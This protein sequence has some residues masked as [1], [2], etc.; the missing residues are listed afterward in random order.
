M[1]ELAATQWWMSGGRPLR[2]RVE[3]L[4]PLYDEDGTADWVVVEGGQQPPGGGGEQV[5]VLVRADALPAWARARVRLTR[6]EPG[7]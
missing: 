2:M 6:H 5:R 3:R 4:T 7:A 1:L